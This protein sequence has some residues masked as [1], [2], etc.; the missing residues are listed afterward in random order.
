M[1]RRDKDLNKE[2]KTKTSIIYTV[3]PLSKNN[4]KG[5]TRQVIKLY[6]RI[7]SNISSNLITPVTRSSNLREIQRSDPLHVEVTIEVRY[8]VVPVSD[9]NGARDLAK[10]LTDHIGKV[11]K[12]PIKPKNSVIE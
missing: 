12:R 5:I 4:K 11:R 8:G 9:G 10:L 7:I 1:G 2:V 6:I 3:N